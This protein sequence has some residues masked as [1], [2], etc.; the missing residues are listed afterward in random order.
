MHTQKNGWIVLGAVALVIIAGTSGMSLSTPENHPLSTLEFEPKS[1]DFGSLLPGVQL[2]TTFEIWR[3]GSCCEIIYAIAEEYPYL[4]VFPTSGS[5]NGEHDLITVMLDSTGVPYGVYRCPLN[6]TS[7]YGGN[8]VYW[9]NFSVVEYTDPTLACTPTELDFGFVPNNTTVH[10][11][12]SIWN[13]GLGALSYTLTET[14]PW[15]SVSPANGTSTGEVDTV[16]VI[17]TTSN[18]PPEQLE[19]TIAIRSNGGDMDIPVTLL[20]SGI[21][22]IELST[23]KGKVTAT[24]ANV[25]TKIIDDLRWQIHV[26]G[27]FLNLLDVSTSGHRTAFAPDTTLEVSTGVPLHGLGPI[28]VTAS[29]EYAKPI[30]ARGFIF[31]SFIHLQ[32]T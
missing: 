16:T 27:G 18:L 24:L 8:G 23:S 22:I 31:F 17:V 1:H 5:S 4:S 13:A 28:D 9:V 15:L 6:I 11:N 3:G 7:D 21:E 29:V 32:G 26:T 20:L 19:T 10:S 25:G 2:N 30:A 14:C 12:L